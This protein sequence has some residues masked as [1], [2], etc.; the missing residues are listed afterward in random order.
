M[1]SDKLYEA[2]E[3]LKVCPQQAHIQ[4]GEQFSVSLSW[5]VWSVVAYVDWSALWYLQ[6]SLSLQGIT[7]KAN[8]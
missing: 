1:C 4:N 6:S 5:F 7:A 2:N 8:K 3:L